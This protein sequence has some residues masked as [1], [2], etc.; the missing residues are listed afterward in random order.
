MSG[1]DNNGFYPHIDTSKPV[2]DGFYDMAKALDH[3]ETK[4]AGAIVIL[5]YEADGEGTSAIY[6]IGPMGDD[7][8]KRYLISSL[9][10]LDCV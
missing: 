8:V 9:Y 1:H 6:D 3:A 4:P 7:L 10:K 5:C 2:R